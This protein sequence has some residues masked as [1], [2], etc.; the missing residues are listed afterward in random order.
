MINKISPPSIFPLVVD[1]F[2]EGLF[3]SLDVGG[4]QMSL[5]P[6]GLASGDAPPAFHHT[7][8]V[9]AF[10]HTYNLNP[11][12]SNHP[13][14]KVDAKHLVST[15]SSS[16]LGVDRV[17]THAISDIGSA[18]MLLTNN[19]RFALGVLGLLVSATFIY[20]E[21]SASYVFGANRGVL[22][23]DASF[24]SVTIGGALIGKT[25]TF[26]GDAKANT[27]LFQNSTVTVTLDKQI[28]SNFL[29]PSG[30]AASAPTAFNRITTDAIDIHLSNA[31]L[32]GKTISGDITLGETSASLFPP[33]H[34]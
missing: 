16:R 6:V 4:H 15:A 9:R 33:L 10:D 13:T 31:H 12:D 19:P 23:G 14:L 5:G 34:A 28:R 3:A 22:G 21:S 27:V 25:L 7:T 29:P 32:F 1:S 24:G 8:E 17:S 30:A 18:N 26:A 20:S 11:A 2:V